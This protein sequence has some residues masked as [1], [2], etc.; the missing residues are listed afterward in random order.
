MYEKLK[1]KR[2]QNIVIDMLISFGRVKLAQDQSTSL[3]RKAKQLQKKSI[4]TFVLVWMCRYCSNKRYVI[5]L[6]QIDK[7]IF[8][9]SAHSGRLML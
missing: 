6:T 5:C 3:A 1:L 7:V 8:R 4:S 2:T 9:Q